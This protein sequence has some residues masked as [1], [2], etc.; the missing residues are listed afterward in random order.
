VICE[1]A[2]ARRFGVGLVIA[3]TLRWA[4][5]AAIVLGAHG[6]VAW[7]ALRETPAQPM[8]SEAP[9]AVMIELASIAL[10]PEAPPQDVAP[11]PQAAEAQPESEPEPQPEPEPVPEPE[12]EP[13]PV[14]QPEPEPVVQPEPPPPEVKPAEIK[15]PELPKQ[16]KAEAVL[17]PPPPPAKKKPPRKKKPKVQQ[18]ERRKPIDPDRQSQRQTSAPPAAK[19]ERA[20]RLVAPSAGASQASSVSP[21]TWKGALSAHLNRY[22]RFP[23]DAAGAGTA[24]V[25]FTIS[26][27]GQV[28]SARL[29]RSSGDAALDREAVALPRRASPVPPP[30]AGFGGS[31]VTLSVPIRFNS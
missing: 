17:A 1:R 31:T 22:K 15:P 30:P 8:A 18:A 23:S 28:L 26:R 9:P 12:P 5:A 13:Q 10:A 21:S 2:P 19:A 27:S 7:L 29:V 25:A 6:G 14:A 20:D 3:A 11:G 24:S 16:E 4:S